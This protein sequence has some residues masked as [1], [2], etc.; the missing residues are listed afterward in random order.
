MPVVI[1][2]TSMP[3]NKDADWAERLDKALKGEIS[4]NEITEIPGETNN[5]GKVKKIHHFKSKKVFV[6]GS[7]NNK[8]IVPET[9][10]K[11]I[12]TKLREEKL[13]AKAKR[14]E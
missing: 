1:K 10:A 8:K 12:R 5:E 3:T 14:N 6:K 11:Q 9:E 7:S 4:G 2:G 13:A